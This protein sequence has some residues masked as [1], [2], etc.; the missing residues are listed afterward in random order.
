MKKALL[1]IAIASAFGVAANAANTITA[2]NVEGAPGSTV[3]VQL[4]LT[5]DAAVAGFQ[6]NI[7]ADKAGLTLG[8]ATLGTRTIA[9]TP[10][11]GSN[12]VSSTSYNVLMYSP[13]CNTYTGAATQT[14][15]VIPVTIPS[16]ATAG[17]TY[18]L[19]IQN[20][21]VSNASG[22][23]AN[24]TSSTVTVKVSNAVKG[25]MTGDGAVDI[26]DVTAAIK[27]YRTGTYDAKADLVADGVINLFDITAMIK[28]YRKN[29]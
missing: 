27:L 29:K 20:G 16:S 18:T 3:N 10:W 26:L 15:A 28:E 19:T 22:V 23:T 7:A 11:I 14:V 13:E 21:I 12:A 24:C 2:T 1:S 4:V 9:G 5:N 6:A 25:D 17:T 8:A